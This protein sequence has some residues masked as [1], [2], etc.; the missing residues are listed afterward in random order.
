IARTPHLELGRLVR[1]QNLSGAA[2]GEIW[3]PHPRLLTMT[4]LGILWP[5]Y[6]ITGFDASVLA[7]PS[8]ADGARQGDKVFA[9]LMTRT[10]P[11]AAGNALWVGIVAAN[12]LCG[13]A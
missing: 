6:T 11:G 2:G 8:M 13:L 10:L 3:P 9:W 4:L 5:V 7:L 12:Y 1:F